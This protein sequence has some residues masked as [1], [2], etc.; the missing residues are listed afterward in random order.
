M[1]VPSKILAVAAILALSPTG[2]LANPP[3]SVDSLSPERSVS[4]DTIDLPTRYV[5]LPCKI[6]IHGDRSPGAFFRQNYGEGFAARGGTVTIKQV[7][8]TV[9]QRCENPKCS[10]L[11]EDWHA[12]SYDIV[13]E[14]ESRILRLQAAA[15]GV[16]RGQRA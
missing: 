8:C 7:T 1:T 6:T 10:G 15:K 16:G 14:R 9:D 5:A 11:N 12:T 2:I 13:T 3:A 4:P